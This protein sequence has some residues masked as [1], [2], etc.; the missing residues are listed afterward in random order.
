MD[1]PHRHG[2]ALDSEGARFAEVK[3]IVA[4]VL[5]VA[6][7]IGA[8]AVVGQRWR[9]KGIDEAKAKAD[10]D[11]SKVLVRTNRAFLLEVATVRKEAQREVS[12]AREHE[13]QADSIAAAAERE[14]APK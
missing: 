5:G 9:Q 2:T 6:L 1:A 14:P 7:M 11:H 13:R 10:R 8:I 3:K 12:E 4:I